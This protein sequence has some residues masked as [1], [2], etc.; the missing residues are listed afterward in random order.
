MQRDQVIDAR[1]GDHEAFNALVAGS[2]DRL[3]AVARLILRDEDLARDGVQDALVRAWVGLPG[4][5]HPDR[6]DAWLHRLLVNA[7][8]HEA[9]DARNRRFVAIGSLSADALAVGDVQD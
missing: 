2:I 8:Y 3:Y 6:F 1:A 9:R 5:R 4:L 7:C